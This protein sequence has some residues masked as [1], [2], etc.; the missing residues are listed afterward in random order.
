MTHILRLKPLLWMG[1]LGSLSLSL[2]EYTCVS[3]YIPLQPFGG[4][5]KALEDSSLLKSVFQ[6][7]IK[8]RDVVLHRPCFY[9]KAKVEGIRTITDQ[10]SLLGFAQF[11]FLVLYRLYFSLEYYV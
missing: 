8:G 9:R 7:K 4:I 3:L 10:G 2:S 11:S 5:N 1:V 6:M